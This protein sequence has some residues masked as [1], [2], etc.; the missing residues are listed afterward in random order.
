MV[1]L[2]E[3]AFSDDLILVRDIEERHLST[4]PEVHALQMAGVTCPVLR[5]G[6]FDI[7]RSSGP[8][9]RAKMRRGSQ[10]PAL[11]EGFLSPGPDSPSNRTTKRWTLPV[12]PL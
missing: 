9:P 11:V 10:V 3:V 8:S 1:L 12:R 6:K 4:Y 7:D 2:L 5:A